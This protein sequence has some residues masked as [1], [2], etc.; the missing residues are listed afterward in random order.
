MTIDTKE[1]A[2]EREIEHWL[3]A[4]ADKTDRYVKGKPSNYDREFAMD[5][6]AVIAFIKDTQPDIWQSLCKR[7][8][9]EAEGEAEFFKRL[10]SQLNQ[11]GMIDILRHGVVDLGIAV[12]LAYFKPGS[13]MNKSAAALYDKNVLQ[14]T[15]QV[16]YSLTN[17]NSIDAVIFLN[18]LPIITIELKNPFTGQTSKNAIIQYQSDR[19]PRE[20]LLAFKKRAIVHFAVDT[21]EVWMTTCLRKLDTVFLPFNKGNDKGAGNPPVDG[22]CRTSYLWKEV[23]RRDSILDILHRFVQLTEDEKSGKEKL[24]FPRY[25]QLDA[26]RELV[27]DVYRNGSGKNY[28]IQHSAGSGK[29]NSIAWLAHHLANLH[30]AGD[31]VVFHSIIVITDRH[32]L[33]KQLQRDIYN[34]EHK[35]GVVVRVDKNSKQ[36]TIALEKGYKIIVCTLQ[37]FP[38]VDVRKVATAGKRFAIIVDEAHS[39][40][41]GKASERLK[42]VLAD[43][44]A[45]GDDAIEKKLREY[46]ALEAKAEAEEL[47]P[48]EEIAAEMAAHGQ[49]KNLSF[50]AFTATPKQKTLEIFGTKTA[51]GKPEPFHL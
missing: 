47:D 27:D 18:G 46:A 5:K 4:G 24:I 28:L 7:H 15:R 3:T 14:I 37:K 40:Q 30:D 34:M 45:R 49:Q 41:T 32:V 12:R 50:F 23:L 44:S 16:K 36:L 26:V 29:S 9:S 2:F 19:N 1:R 42:E 10:N 21:E 39:S 20:T 11:R 31:D 13:G 51:A 38:F 33:D 22:D 43:I 17:E 25:H 6:G 35:A 8:G 48:D